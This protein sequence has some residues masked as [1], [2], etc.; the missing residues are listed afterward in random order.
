M[1]ARVRM[2]V[3]RDGVEDGWW[4]RV[5]VGVVTGASDAA[6]VLS[7]RL[8]DFQ[9]HDHINGFLTQEHVNLVFG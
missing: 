4:S 6:V 3:G 5:A 1:T 8:L 7:Q 9:C 2:Q